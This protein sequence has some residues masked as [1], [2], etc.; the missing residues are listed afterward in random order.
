MLEQ[1]KSKG[2]DSLASLQPLL[3]YKEAAEILAVKPQTLRQWVSAKRIPYVKIGAA[4]RFSPYQLE[5]FIR[6]SSR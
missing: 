4:V 2:I 1:Q 3:T 5:D 6:G